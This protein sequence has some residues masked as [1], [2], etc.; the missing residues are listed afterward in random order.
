MR[1]FLKQ[2]KHKII[3]GKLL[4][5]LYVSINPYEK[6]SVFDYVY[7]A[8]I[9]VVYFVCAYNC[10][11][12]SMFAY[13]S[14][15][16]AA[17]TFFVKIFLIVCGIVTVYKWAYYWLNRSSIRNVLLAID[18]IKVEQ[19]C[20]LVLR[21]K[22]LNA[23]LLTL[24]ALIYFIFAIGSTIYAQSH[25][26]TFYFTFAVP[27]EISMYEQYLLHSVT[28]ELQLQLKYINDYFHLSYLSSKHFT[29]FSEREFVTKYE[30]HKKL[31][32]LTSIAQK[33][34]QI[35]V[36]ASILC[37]I[38]ALPTAICSVSSM[39]LV[40]ERIYFNNF[41]WLTTISIRMVFTVR[42]WDR[43]VTQVNAFLFT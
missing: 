9:A 43:L 42:N 7:A 32:K 26:F 12:S 24:T 14:E 34:F 30:E 2:I 10:Y 23:A 39:V 28:Q 3:L 41:I 22:E 4:G 13:D 19:K 5:V 21:R 35:P 1:A 20:G 16:T 25:V 6:N 31:L 17:Q 40:N 38:L 37:S 15:P 8:P 18:R 36:L 29:K 33:L 11:S 27:M